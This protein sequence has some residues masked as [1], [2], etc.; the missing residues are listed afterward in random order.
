MREHIGGSVT[1][2][3]TWGN[4]DTSFEELGQPVGR[5][6]PFDYL[7]W[8]FVADEMYAGDS[9]DKRKAVLVQL[10]D[11]FF[12]HRCTLPAHPGHG[13]GAQQAL[14]P[15]RAAGCTP[16]HGAV[17]PPILLNVMPNGEI[18]PART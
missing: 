16:G 17:C 1:A 13:H 14:S 8:Q 4:P 6:H 5:R 3:V 18:Y 10:L 15:P 9:L 11:K 7:Y 12:T 2:R